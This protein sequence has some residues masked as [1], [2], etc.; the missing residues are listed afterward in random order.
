MRDVQ[1][2]C[3]AVVEQL[4][5]W[6]RALMAG[7]ID[8][9]DAILA[10]DFQ[11][12]VD[13]RYAG[14]RLNREQFLALDRK[15][16]N[17]SIELLEITARRMGSMVTALILAEVSEEFTGD[18]GPD[19]PSVEEMNARMKEARLAYGSAWRQDAGGT[20]Q[21]FSHHIFGFVD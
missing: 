9:L 7:D 12:T 16:R 5:R 8:Q 17:S 6:T 1:A 20:W 2:G 4:E 11:F 13:P 15:I 14:G 18:L 3:E 21:C 19:M 10:R